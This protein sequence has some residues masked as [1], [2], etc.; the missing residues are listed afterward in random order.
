MRSATIIRP[1]VP[2][3]CGR[4]ATARCGFFPRSRGASETLTSL[5]SPASHLHSL[6]V[7][8]AY[9]SASAPPRRRK[10][11][12]RHQSRCWGPVTRRRGANQAFRGFPGI[13]S[14]RARPARHRRVVVNAPMRGVMRATA[15]ACARARGAIDA[16]GARAHR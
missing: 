12:R 2:G 3:A 14:A 4:R 7:P 5:Y 6:V 13:I 11:S 10:R 9:A 1:T 15:R 16:Q 8:R